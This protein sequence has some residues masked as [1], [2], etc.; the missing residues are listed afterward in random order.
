MVVET[1]GERFRFGADRDIGLATD[2]GLVDDRQ[3]LAAHLR[4]AYDAVAAA[5]PDVSRHAEALVMIVQYRAPRATDTSF[6]AGLNLSFGDAALV[7]REEA[8]R[9]CA[10]PSAS[11]LPRRAGG[12]WRST[13][14]STT[15]GCGCPSAARR[16]DRAPTS[17]SRRS[18]PDRRRSRRQP[19]L[20][21]A[22]RDR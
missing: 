17:R 22:R 7:S 19:F 3:T 5:L 10:S 4:A 9:A 11:C 21:L 6:K 18:E 15:K 16:T 1:L 8:A 14:P 2:V 12:G 20:S 13:R